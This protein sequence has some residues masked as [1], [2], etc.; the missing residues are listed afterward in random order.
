MPQPENGVI[1]AN[2]TDFDVRYKNPLLLGSLQ[3]GMVQV[4][5][6]TSSKPLK[7][8]AQIA[9]TP[10]TSKS[11]PQACLTLERLGYPRPERVVI[12]AKDPA[13]ELGLPPNLSKVAFSKLTMIFT[14]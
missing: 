7:T 6:K 8:Y 9:S 2:A 12:L 14:R 1:I 11:L 13:Y 5:M 10:I 3:H 4:K